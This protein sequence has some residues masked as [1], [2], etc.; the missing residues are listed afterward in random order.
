MKTWVIMAFLAMSSAA[1]ASERVELNSDQLTRAGVVTRP[2]LERSFGDQQRVVGQVVRTPGSTVNLKTMVAGRVERLEVAPGDHVRMGQLVAALHSHEILAMQGE[3]LRAAQ[4]S[5]L[6]ETRLEAGRELFS[7]D[8]ISRIDLE[9]REQEAFTA[10]LEFDTTYHELVDHGLPESEL[11]AMLE[12]RKPDAHLF[13]VSP[14]D[15]VVLELGVQIEEWIQEYASVVTIGDP[16]RV[17]LELQIAPAL[18]EKVSVGDVVDFVPVGRPEDSGRATVITRVPQV[19]P[20]TRTVRIRASIVEKG[21]GLFPG[22]FVE[23]VLTQGTAR[24]APSVP[25]SAVIGVGGVDVVFVAVGSGVFERRDVELGLTNG[26]RYEV[27][28]GVG[29]GEEVAVK[30]V[31]FLKSA[32]MKSAG[33]DK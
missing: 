19:D 5:K 20:D 11:D 13:I 1:T 4:R 25:E 22:A 27:V 3:L 8:G 2:V 31:F 32:L 17:E 30:G 23:G 24:L 7:V 12:S 15:G 9:V 28:S 29:V 16:E 26:S 6:A 14:T 18:A 10:H 21:G 33:E